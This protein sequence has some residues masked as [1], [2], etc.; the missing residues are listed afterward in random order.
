M[1]SQNGDPGAPYPTL[2]MFLMAIKVLMATQARPRSCIS[3][4]GQS[5]SAHA[6]CF[7]SWL[8]LCP[9]LRGAAPLAWGVWPTRCSQSQPNKHQPGRF[10]TK[11]KCYFLL[12]WTTVIP[13]LALLIPNPLV[14]FLL[15]PRTQQGLLAE[16]SNQ[17][18]TGCNKCWGK[19]REISKFYHWSSLQK[20]IQDSLGQR[21]NTR[22]SKSL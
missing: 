13:S 15:H 12:R 16:R 8:S 1:C 10:P 4:H 22:G 21:K 7:I 18:A 20:V 14:P 6:G 19:E 11:F 5:L 2:E 3:V 9:I 17:S